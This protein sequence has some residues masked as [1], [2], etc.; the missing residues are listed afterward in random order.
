[1]RVRALRQLP[2]A[3]LQKSPERMSIVSLEAPAQR[4]SPAVPTGRTPE[5]AMG[6]RIREQG[7][8][9]IIEIKARIATSTIEIDDGDD[10]VIGADEMLLKIIERMLGRLAPGTGPTEPSRFAIRERLSSDRSS[11]VRLCQ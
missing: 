4:R 11:A 2:V 10:S 1:M 7:K 6:A 5:C 9:L 8:S 3:I